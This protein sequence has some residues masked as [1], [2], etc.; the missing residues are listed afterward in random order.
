MCLI[1]TFF[2]IA[3][4]DLILKIIAPEHGVELKGRLISSACDKFIFPPKML[5]VAPFA[6]K[7]V[8]AA[9]NIMQQAVGEKKT[10]HNLWL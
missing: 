5:T 4:I 7:T 3:C 1:W 10:I 2:P 8:G 9:G 6:A